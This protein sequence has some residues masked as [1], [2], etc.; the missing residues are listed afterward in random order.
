MYI[1]TRSYIIQLKWLQ[2]SLYAKGAI[3][4]MFIPA[5]NT[6][7]LGQSISCWPPST[8][9]EWSWGGTQQFAI[10]PIIQFLGQ[11]LMK[12]DYTNISIASYTIYEQTGDGQ[13]RMDKFLIKKQELLSLKTTNNGATTNNYLLRGSSSSSITIDRRSHGRTCTNCNIFSIFLP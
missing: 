1:L 8:G 3:H 11:L 12:C 2:L 10:A 9:L 5:L 6:D 13:V 4:K 7:A